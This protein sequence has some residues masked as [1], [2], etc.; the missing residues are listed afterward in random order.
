M[1]QSGIKLQWIPTY[2]K[3]LKSLN[4]MAHGKVKLLQYDYIYFKI[5]E[6]V[7]P[8]EPPRIHTG[9]TIEYI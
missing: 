9:E 2:T 3:E 8:K 1:I 6:V 7:V 4:N 5:V